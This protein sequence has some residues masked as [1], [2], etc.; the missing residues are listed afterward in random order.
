MGDDDGMETHWFNIVVKIV[1]RRNKLNRVFW[2]PWLELSDI[3]NEKPTNRPQTIPRAS[4]A[5]IYSGWR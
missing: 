1:Q 3:Q 5:K 4:L 2:K